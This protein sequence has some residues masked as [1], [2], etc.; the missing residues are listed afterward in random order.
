MS[1]PKR[2]VALD[3]ARGAAI[4]FALLLHYVLFT[5][6]EALSEHEIGMFVAAARV[7]TPTFVMLFGA[8]L[9]IVYLPRARESF[10]PVVRR[11]ATRSAQ[12]YLG[13]AAGVAMTIFLGNATPRGAT[14]SLFFMGHPK[15]NVILAFYAFALLLAPALIYIRMRAGLWAVAALGTGIAI[16]GAAAL[17]AMPWPEAGTPTAALTQVLLGHPTPSRP[18]SVWYLMPWVCGGMVLGRVIVTA[19]D[20]GSRA[21]LFRSLAA[22]I[23]ASL[24]PVA[25]N[26]AIEGSPAAIVEAISTTSRMAHHYA[27]FAL[28]TAISLAFIGGVFIL[29]P[30]DATGPRW[31]IPIIRVGQ[32]SLFSFA[33]GNSLIL[34]FMTRGAHRESRAE[35][36]ALML[37]FLV[38][39]HLSLKGFATARR[40]HKTPAPLPTLEPS[41]V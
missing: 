37:S 40:E 5:S 1:A 30:F 38:I 8:F 36:Y 15:I 12:C 18:D 35:C 33:F 17:P 24:I 3:I 19:R 16:I 10:P 22:G 32:H 31:T 21:F 25:A 6:A 11:L 7:G 26:A 4:L 2:I 23:A 28:A 9:E 27:Y 34:T 41:R 39:L 20:R 13:Y 14:L 29:F